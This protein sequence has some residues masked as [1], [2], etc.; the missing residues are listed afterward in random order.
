MKNSL[1][2]GLIL[3]LSILNINC[4]NNKQSNPQKI[5]EGIT[6]ISPESFKEKSMNQVIIDVR[7][8]QEFQAGHIEGALNINYFDKNFLEQFSNFDKTKPVFIYCKSGNR[9][10]SASPK[11][12]KLGFKEVYDLQGG[13]L[14]WEKKNN[15]TV[16]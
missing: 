1:K 15:S 6:V 5:S 2:L 12:S 16:K 8:P 4:T 13:I 9:S 7:T 11:I 3:F 14:N 10:S